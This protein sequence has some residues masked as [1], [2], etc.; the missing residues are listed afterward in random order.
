M[1]T[2][3]SIKQGYK[4]AGR[5]KDASYTEVYNVN[6]VKLIYARWKERIT[7]NVNGHGTDPEAVDV[8]LNETTVLP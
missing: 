5:Y 6:D 1:P 4:F 8:I 2:L 3:T 7:Y